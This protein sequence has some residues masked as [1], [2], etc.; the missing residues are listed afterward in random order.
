MYFN[1]YFKN[2]GEH[3]KI[4]DLLKIGNESGRV[5]ALYDI[6]KE[7]TRLLTKATQVEFLTTLR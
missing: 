6:F 2:R 1:D 5:S 4:K 3:M 7:E